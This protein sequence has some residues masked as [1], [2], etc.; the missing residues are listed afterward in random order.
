[1]AGS[2]LHIFD[3]SQGDSSNYDYKCVPTSTGSGSNDGPVGRYG[4]AA[5]VVDGSIYVFGGQSEKELLTERNYFWRFD[6]KA[7]LWSSIEVSKGNISPQ[8]RCFH[9]AVSD[10]SSIVIYGGTSQGT[11][12]TDVWQF[13]VSTGSWA[14]L[15]S[16]KTSEVNPHPN[17]ALADGVLYVVEQ[18]EKSETVIYSLALRATEPAWQTVMIPAQLT[19]PSPRQGAGLVPITTGM[20]RLY[21]LYMLGEKTEPSESESESG[22][23]S[24]EPEFWSGLWSYQ[25]DST[26]GTLAKLK[27]ATKEKLGMDSQRA[28]WAEV[29]IKP[30]T[31]QSEQGK[32]HPG[33][34]G[35]FAVDRLN[36]NTVILWGGANAKGEVEGDGWIITLE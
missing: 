15:P 34:R 33:P 29:E 24:E 16:L 18:N 1:M 5:A 36:Q 19:S 28:T 9:T 2:D 22:G 12:L 11:I 31:E 23:K 21:L 35:Q 32:S 6:T 14:S 8:P 10:D 27:D 4:H 25:I 20:G 13:D 30:T 17:M 3:L 26:K 7:L